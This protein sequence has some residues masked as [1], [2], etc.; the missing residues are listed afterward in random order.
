MSPVGSCNRARARKTRVPKSGLTAPGVLQR[1][2][3]LA[4]E[5]TVALFLPSA[6]F[7][8][9]LLVSEFIVFYSLRASA[10]LYR[11]TCSSRRHPVRPTSVGE[12]CFSTWHSL[13]PASGM[14]VGRL[15][16]TFKAHFA[17]GLALWNF[18]YHREKNKPGLDHWSQEERTRCVGLSDPC[19]CRRDLLP[20]LGVP[21]TETSLHQLTLSSSP[22]V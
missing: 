1:L 12:M 5:W 21:P 19:S 11:N 7:L 14:L 17:S 13:S 15:Y 16:H 22:D 18:W 2:R 10:R 3:K 8:L 4:V 20:R 6:C 9:V